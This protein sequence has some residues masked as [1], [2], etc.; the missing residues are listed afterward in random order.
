MEHFDRLE[1]RSAE[2][3]EADLFE[4]LPQQ[5]A[6]A[7]AAAAYFTKL[8]ADV[9]T[10]T[11][12]DRA[13]LAGLP[14]TRKGDLL[15]LQPAAPPFGGL[16]TIAAGQA[17]RLF[18]SPGPIYDLETDGPDYWG[19][20]RALFAAGFRA[21]DILHNSFSYHL[22]PGAWIIDGGARAMGCAVIPAGT[23]NSEQQVQT[24]AHLRPQGFAG[25]PDYLKILLDKA[26]EIG[27]DCSSITKGLVS[28]GALFPA[29]RA[30]YAERGVKILQAYATAD[31]GLVAYESVADEGLLVA[32]N[33][34]LEIV[35][36]GTGD[37][38]AAGEVGEVVITK[39]DPAYPLL[40]FGTGDLSTMLVGRSPCGRT[41]SRIK[42]WMGRADQAAKVRG[43]FVQP[44]QIA[45]VVKRHA[46]I[47]KARLVVGREGDNDS[48]AL[49]CESEISDVAL[50]A[51]IGETLQ[52]CCKLRGS[53]VLVAP[54]SLANDGIVIEDQ[55]TY[56]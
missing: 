34:I 5:L 21:G 23:G 20:A 6:T 28:G 26:D 18:A 46:E 2:D 12:T 31:L 33:I 1:T 45:L 3:R 40:R 54:G 8:L 17:A 53:V 37:P 9:D 13:A 39:L 38:V 10:S 36:P 25:T 48:M 43:M 41:A 27:V 51:E 35:R 24:I 22:S 56:D 30:A 50:A 49:H 16:A 44:S 7:K 32:E 42:G 11:I 47:L 52:S 4:R 14:V 29:Q 19:S 15:T 55:R